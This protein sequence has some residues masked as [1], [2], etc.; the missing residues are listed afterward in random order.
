LTIDPVSVFRFKVQGSMVKNKRCQP[1][2]MV[3]RLNKSG[4]GQMSKASGHRQATRR[5]N[6]EPWNL[7]PGL[8]LLSEEEPYDE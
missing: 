1:G 2:S 8:N 6:P 3:Q 4:I 7:K 5:L